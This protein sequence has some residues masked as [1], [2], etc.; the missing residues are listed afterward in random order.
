[1]TDRDVAG[2]RSQDGDRRAGLTQQPRRPDGRVAG[3]R[4][5]GRRREDPAR[6]ADP[7]VDEHGLGEVE[8]GRDGL[9]PSL[10]SVAAVEEHTQ[11]IAA[12]PV[13]PDEDPENVELGH[14]VPPDSSATRVN[15][16]RW[17]PMIEN[18]SVIRPSD[19]IASASSNG[20]QRTSI[21]SVGSGVASPWVSPVAR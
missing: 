7:V 17:I 4:E 9:S 21:C 18:A 1:M 5:L 12:A 20:T 10:R 11:R 6:A 13:R 19:V 2:R 3:K 14:W 16:T 8:V 15:A